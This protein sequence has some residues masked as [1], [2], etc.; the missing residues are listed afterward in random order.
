[1]R[2]LLGRLVAHQNRGRHGGH[3]RGGEQCRPCAACECARATDGGAETETRRAT[4]CHSAVDFDGIARARERERDGDHD[5][6]R[7]NT[8]RHVDVIALGQSRDRRDG[9]GL[10]SAIGDLIVLAGEGAT[11][12]RAEAGQKRGDGIP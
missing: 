3:H 10:F 1:M 5:R 6:A 9:G 12:V 7:R 11:I 4:G 2:K 8:R